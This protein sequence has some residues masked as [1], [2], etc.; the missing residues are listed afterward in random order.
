MA[1]AAKSGRTLSLQ[2][3]SLVKGMVSRGDR[4]HDIAS[5]FGVNQGRIAEVNDGHLHPTA[6]PAPAD[7]LPPPGPYS[8]GQAAHMAIAALE[9]AKLALETA[10]KNIEQALKSVKT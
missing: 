6:R 5:W 8:S 2:D 10:A 7:Q 3:A 1:R 4:H 9:E